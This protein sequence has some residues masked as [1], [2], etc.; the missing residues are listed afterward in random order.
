MKASLNLLVTF[1]MSYITHTI[2]KNSPEGI[3]RLEKY[4]SDFNEQVPSVKYFKFDDD[5][6]V[7]YTIYTYNE[8]DVELLLCMD[9]FI[10]FLVT[11]K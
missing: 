5:N 6:S 10:K 8:D 2:E 11:I 9:S 3:I 4:L 7:H 1:N